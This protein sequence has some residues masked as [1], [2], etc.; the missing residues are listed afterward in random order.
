MKTIRKLILILLF[1]LLSVG[2]DR[3]HPGDPAH[4]GVSETSPASTNAP[5][6]TNVPAST[7]APAST[8]VPASTSVPASTN[9]PTPP[10]TPTPTYIFMP[11]RTAVIHK[12]KV[13]VFEADFNEIGK[14]SSGFFDVEKIPGWQSYVSKPSQ[15]ENFRGNLILEGDLSDSYLSVVADK[16]EGL[17]EGFGQKMEFEI[18]LHDYEIRDIIVLFSHHNRDNQ[19]E[20]SEELPHEPA[21]FLNFSCGNKDNKIGLFFGRY[22]RIV[23]DPSKNAYVTQL[24]L[25]GGVETNPFNQK[26]IDYFDWN[27][28]Y[29]QL[30]MSFPDTVINI[31]KL[32]NLRVDLEDFDTIDPLDQFN[33]ENYLPEELDDN[34]NRKVY[35]AY[36][37][38]GRVK[39]N[40]KFGAELVNNGSVDIRI[41]KV[42]V[43]LS[44]P[45]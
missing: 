36:L 11:F 13:L 29:F 18:D 35:T 31:N 30:I 15:S 14:R 21:L 5:A 34:H 25:S 40:L 19:W 8:N 1:V 20:I 41:Y 10:N 39:T 16:T 6:S 44:P 38:C 37:P 17:K 45:N 32:E 27:E 24:D 33:I 4:T 23:Y 43:I 9:A 42:I 2:C 26:G 22:E 3:S 7:N 28:R 12:E